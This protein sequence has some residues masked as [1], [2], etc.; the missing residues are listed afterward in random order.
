MVKK[1][2]V[3]LC[4]KEFIY[5]KQFDISLLLF[6]S[7]IEKNE[8]HGNIIYH[9]H[10][11]NMN[12]KGSSFHLRRIQKFNPQNFT[13]C[14]TLN[15]PARCVISDRMQLLEFVLNICGWFRMNNVGNLSS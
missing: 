7:T 6:V 2:F 15:Y 5:S 4:V 9:E 8:K 1:V 11:C 14:S 3:F 10:Q 12:E 13:L